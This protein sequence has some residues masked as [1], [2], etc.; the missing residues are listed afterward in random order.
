MRCTHQNVT[1]NSTIKDRAE[2]LA[3]LT[4]SHALQ[5]QVPAACDSDDRMTKIVLN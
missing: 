1:S 5:P 3:K 2:M 4:S